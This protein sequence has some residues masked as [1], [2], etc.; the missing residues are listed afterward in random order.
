MISSS[1]CFWGL[2]S[3]CNSFVD[4]GDNFGNWMFTGLDECSLDTAG[5]GDGLQP[6]SFLTDNLSSGVFE[7]VDVISSSD[8]MSLLIIFAVILRSSGCNRESVGDDTDDWWLLR[9]SSIDD[10][11]LSEFNCSDADVVIIVVLLTTASED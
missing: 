8:L 2:S 1:G 9:K 3:V 7:G 4:C 6:N 11:F 10:D 5:G